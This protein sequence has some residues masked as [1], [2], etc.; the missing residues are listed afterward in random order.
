MLIM[1]RSQAFVPGFGGSRGDLC[2]G[3]PCYR[4]FD[5]CGN[6][7]AGEI[8]SSPTSRAPA[9]SFVELETWNFQLWYRDNNQGDLEHLG[10]P[11]GHVRR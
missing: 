7:P 2:L 9:G 11:R 3:E 1:A 5:T 4:Y 10:R 8:T 6:G